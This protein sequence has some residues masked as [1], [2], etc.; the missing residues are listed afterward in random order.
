MDEIIYINKRAKIFELIKKVSD[1]YSGDEINWLRAYA[2][3]RVLHHKDN[4]D[5]LL[6]CFLDLERQIDEQLNNMVII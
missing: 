4:L 2:L 3:E 5:P 1:H 6:E